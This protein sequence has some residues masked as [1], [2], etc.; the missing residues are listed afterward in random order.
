MTTS[1]DN[2]EYGDSAYNH[3]WEKVPTLGSSDSSKGDRQTVNFQHF[4]CD[5]KIRLWHITLKS[6]RINPHLIK[7]WY[8]NRQSE[9]GPTQPPMPAENSSIFL[10]QEQALFPDS[11]RPHTKLTTFS[12]ITLQWL[13]EF[14]SPRNILNSPVWF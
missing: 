4:L 10:G 1:A 14:I 2:Q 5:W 11:S 3:K 9:L 6:L 7:Y 12:I 8:Y 13:A